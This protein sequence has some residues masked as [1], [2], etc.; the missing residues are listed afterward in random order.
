MIMAAQIIS[1]CSLYAFV[2]TNFNQ[3]FYD[4]FDFLSIV[5]DVVRFSGAGLGFWAVIVE[6][7]CKRHVQRKFW[8]IY[9]Q[10]RIDFNPIDRDVMFRTYLIKFGEFFVVAIFNEM[11]NFV[12]WFTDTNFF[13]AISYFSSMMMHY[14]RIFH[15]LFFIHLLDHQLNEVELQMKLM[16]DNSEIGIISRDCL[17]SIRI[18][19]DLVH[20]LSDCIN[21]VFGWSNIVSVLFVF[22][23]LAV[24]LN[25]TYWRLHNNVDVP[26]TSTYIH[27]PIAPPSPRLIWPDV[28]FRCSVAISKY[29]T[30]FLYIQRYDEVCDQGGHLQKRSSTNWN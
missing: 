11:I 17:K 27:L 26:T 12:E 2:W 18:Y 24:D 30:D 4:G 23:R 22:L 25:W 21:E 15:Y 9:R 16:A 8:Q 1:T 19:Y 6:S 13:F 14:M 7:Y 10:I 5:N 28:F 3:R 29:Y 20:D